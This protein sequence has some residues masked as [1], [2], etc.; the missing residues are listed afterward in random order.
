MRSD[1]GV[2]EGTGEQ[3][4]SHRVRGVAV[5]ATGSGDSGWDW[6]CQ[7]RKSWAC[8]PKETTEL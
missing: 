5:A 6:L 7:S 8:C 4:L 3:R 1:A 2:D